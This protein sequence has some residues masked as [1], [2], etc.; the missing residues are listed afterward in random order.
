MDTAQIFLNIAV[1]V[2][3]G[4]AISA[5]G[6]FIDNR[7]ATFTDS[8]DGIFRATIIA[9]VFATGLWFLGLFVFGD[10]FNPYGTAMMGGSGG[11][12]AMLVATIIHRRRRSRL[13]DPRTDALHDIFS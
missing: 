13:S 2:L 6:W 7:R 12:I 8:S 5:M 4:S 11:A 1:I 10:G 9:S 3:N